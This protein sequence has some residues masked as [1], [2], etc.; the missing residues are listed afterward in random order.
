[1]K[2]ICKDL[3]AEC[4]ALD[5]VVAHIDDAAWAAVTPFDGWTVKDE[6][7]HLVY[8]DMLARLSASDKEGFDKEMAKL[9]EKFETLFEYTLEPGR[10]K[11]NKDLLEWWRAERKGM[12]AAY[13]VLD[14]KAR[15]PWHLP[16]SARSSATAR[17]METWAH[18]QDIVDV[19]GASRPASDRLKHIAHLGVA[20]FGWSFKCRGMEA[21]ENPVRVELQSP[22][23]VLWAWGAEDGADTITGPAEDFCLVVAQRRHYLDTSLK[24]TG[25]AATD[26]MTHAQI[27]AGPPATGPKPGT[28]R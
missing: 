16:M 5:D 26:W 3:A 11:S 13:E 7:A 17:L 1:M 10:A 23:G 2:D 9:I 6:I 25:K 21:P 8:F 4:Q 28:F 15:L 27:F 20:T 24:V 12:I 19:L 18:G 22:S 14:P